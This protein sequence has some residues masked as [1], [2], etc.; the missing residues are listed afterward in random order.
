MKL[1]TILSGIISL[2]SVLALGSCAKVA[3]TDKHDEISDFSNKAL[4]QVY[5]GIVSSG[6]SLIGVDNSPV[7]GTSALSYAGAF[8]SANFFMAEPGM[9]AMYIKP[10]SSTSVQTPLAFTHNFNANTRYSIFLYD[11]LN[12]AKQL[13]VPT[14][15]EIP[16]DTTAR[17]RLANIIFSRTAVPA[18]DVFSVKRNANVFTNV[19]TTQV[20]NYIP[21]ASGVNDTLIVRETGTTNQLFQMINFNPTRRRSYT[22]VFRG[23]YQ[24]TSG[25]IARTLSSFTN[26]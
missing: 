2:G 23:R 10:S 18:I 7:N 16:T 4:I 19:Q 5:N 9:R 24:S 26:Y 8:P 3:D 1:L 12:A 21:Y 22:L 17:V 14:N 15:I 13:I 20:T 11:T 6:G 25:T